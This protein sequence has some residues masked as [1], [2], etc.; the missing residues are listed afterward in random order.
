MIDLSRRTL[1]TLPEYARPTGDYSVAGS[2]LTFFS[3]RKK[4]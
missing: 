3:E 4:Q 2:D 1:F